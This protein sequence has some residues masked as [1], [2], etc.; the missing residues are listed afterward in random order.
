[1]VWGICQQIL[2]CRS[3]DFVVHDDTQD[4]WLCDPAARRRAQEQEND[5]RTPYSLAL[6]HH[7]ESAG[8]QRKKPKLKT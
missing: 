8:G 7:F 5:G 3:N 6:P 2:R 1:M 4:C